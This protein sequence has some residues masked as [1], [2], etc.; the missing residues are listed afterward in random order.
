MKEIILLLL[1][2]FIVLPTHIQ[3][4]PYYLLTSTR[5]KCVTVEGPRDTTLQVSYDAPDMVL[6]PEDDS[7]QVEKEKKQQHI[8]GGLDARFNKRYQDKMIALAR[9][10]RTMVDLSITIHQRDTVSANREW[11]VAGGGANDKGS[12]R[13]R[14]ELTQR[15]GSID[16]TTSSLRDAPVEICVQ[17]MAANPKNPSRV[18]LTVVQSAKISKK[19]RALEQEQRAQK[20]MSRLAEELLQLD[21]KA[22]LLLTQADYAKDQEAEFHELSVQMNRASHYWPMIHLLILLITG[23]TQANHIIRFFKAHHII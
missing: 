5:P 4:A 19:K 21:R 8:S 3:S 12:G 22:D 7:E 15:K 14:R 1:L 2:L 13:V 11:K 20:Q 6:L 18:A 16:Y 17:S 10:G 9:A 23:F